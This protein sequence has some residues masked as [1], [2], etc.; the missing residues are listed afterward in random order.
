MR[1]LLPWLDR[2]SKRAVDGGGDRGSRRRLQAL[3]ALGAVALVMLSAAGVAQAAGTGSVEGTATNHKAEDL[4]GIEVTVLETG[5]NTV[6]ST[7]TASSGAFDVA[8]I[9]EGVYTVVFTDKTATYLDK[10]VRAVSVEEGTA[11]KLPTVVLTKASAVDGQVTSASS[12]GGLSG[13]SVYIQ[14]RENPS[15]FEETTTEA[16]GRYRF[17]QLEPGEYEMYFS[18]PGGEYLEQTLTI[19]L[20]EGEEHT[21]PTVQL[22]EGGKISGTVTNAYTHTGLE[23][24]QVYAYIPEHGGATA[25]TNSKG[26]YTIS[27][28]SSGAYDVEYYWVY[29][30][31]EDK[32]YEKAPEFVPKYITQYYSNRTSAASAN[33]VSVGEGSTTAGINVAMVPSAPHNTAAP[34]ITGTA[35]VGDALTCSNGSWTG[36]GMLS[37]QAGWPLN[38]PFGY[39][40][41]REGVAISGATS[42]GYLVQSADEGHGL[43]CEV[44]ATNAA[45]HEASKSSSVTVPVAAVAVSSSRLVFVKDTAK[46]SIACANAACSGTVELTARVGAKHGHKKTVVIAKGSYS[47]AAGTHG[48]VAL[49]LTGR[50]AKAMLA[51]RHRTL[52]GKLTVSVKV[53]KTVARAVVLTLAKR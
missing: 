36:E 38:T 53:G 21:V 27:G 28:L 1:W 10:Q 2:G 13:A 43:A 32:E 25:E 46:A 52:P 40:W 31:A 50:G 12:P 24:I 16:S 18:Y 4:K 39:Q 51:A 19:A 17:T 7:T 33:T 41:L 20:V 30:E 35:L 5:G 9:A 26:E 22:S 6:G 29:N 23:K 37:V 34:A 8:G 49:R 47:L 44:T 14:D 15:N 11:T 42:A 45:G 3:A 48:T